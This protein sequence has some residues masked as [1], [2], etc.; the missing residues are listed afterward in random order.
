MLNGRSILVTGGTGSFGKKFIAT[1]LERYP[2]VERIVVYSRDELKQYE[3]AQWLS[4]E[5]YPQLRFFIGDVR[6]KDRLSRAMEGIDTVIHA[7]AL[8]HVPVCEYNP[9]EAVKTNII[10]AQNVIDRGGYRSRCVARGRTVDG[11][12]RSTDQPLRSHQ[13][14]LRQD[15]RGSQQLQGSARPA[16]LGGALRQRH[17]LARQRHPVLPR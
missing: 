12:G 3:M 11:Q 2:E 4:P 10:G 1:I 14:R 7:A 5:R 9:F 15:V 16:L 8:K 17:G 13:A 6:D